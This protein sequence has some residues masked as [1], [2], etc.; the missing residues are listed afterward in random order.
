M[1]T[2]EQT[3]EPFDPFTEPG[4]VIGGGDETDFNEEDFW[5]E[6]FGQ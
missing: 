6:I 2:D 3:T 5:H 4:E 1:F